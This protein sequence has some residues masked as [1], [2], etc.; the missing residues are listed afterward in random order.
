MGNTINVQKA[1]ADEALSL[2]KT[3]FKY[4]VKFSQSLTTGT[5]GF[6]G[7]YAFSEL[8]N[9]DENILVEA[10][11]RQE[12]AFRKDGIHKVATYDPTNSEKTSKKNGV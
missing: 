3:G 7:F 11:K 10:L 12:D 5:L 1:K 4:S 2:Q 8:E 6:E 9:F